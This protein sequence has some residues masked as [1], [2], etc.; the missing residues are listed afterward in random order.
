MTEVAGTFMGGYDAYR[1]RKD[2]HISVYLE[3]ALK[4]LEKKKRE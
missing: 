3:E 4:E 1:K 2:G